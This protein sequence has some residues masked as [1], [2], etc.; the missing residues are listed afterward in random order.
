MLVN[1]GS[2][3]TQAVNDEEGGDGSAYMGSEGSG[4]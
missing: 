2:T 3:L 1:T 4:P